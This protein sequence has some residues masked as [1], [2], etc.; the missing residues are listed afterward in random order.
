MYH[1]KN[2]VTLGGG[3]SVK[4]WEGGVLSIINNK[5]T[6]RIPML[7]LILVGFE[8]GGEKRYTK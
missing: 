8:M 6:L 3:C 5:A 1:T 2:M 7:S 4:E